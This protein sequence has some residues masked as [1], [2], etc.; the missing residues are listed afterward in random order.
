LSL[1]GA[2]SANMNSVMALENNPSQLFFIK[3]NRVE[4]NLTPAFIG[5]NYKDSFTGTTW[6][7]DNDITALAPLTNLGIVYHFNDNLVLGLAGYLN[8]GAGLKMEDIKLGFTPNDVSED[9]D[10]SF[11]NFK[12]SAGG[13]YHINNNLTAGLSLDWS[14]A[15][16]SNKTQIIATANSVKVVSV[17]YQPEL[18]QTFGFNLGLTYQMDNLTF[19][20][21]FS[22]LNKFEFNGPLAL[23][24][25]QLNISNK[26]YDNT[27][28]TFT[29]PERHIL[30]ASFSYNEKLTFLG[31][32][33]YQPYRKYF[34]SSD[35]KNNGTAVLPKQKPRYDDLKYVGIGAEYHLETIDLRCGYGHGNGIC[36]PE[37]VSPT[38][39]FVNTDDITIGAAMK[40]DQYDF[41]I[42]VLYS[43]PANVKGANNSDWNET[44]F[45]GMPVPSAYS[46]E[47][48]GNLLVIGFATVYNF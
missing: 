8:G 48:K 23:T 42:G 11:V 3:G 44:N 10:F 35:L 40:W 24:N 1:A 38:N 4:L 33:R 28:T 9:I 19:A 45:Q 14:A 7:N 26:K 6:K 16:L 29:M 37:S 39:M 12:I 36:G 46:Y 2:T 22:S 27:E 31:E 13:A 43:I 25:L 41:N 32:F 30:G 21:S 15:K 17:D 34:E 47:I 18:T 5:V 20:Y